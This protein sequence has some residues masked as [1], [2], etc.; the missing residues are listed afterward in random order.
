MGGVS[1]IARRISKNSVQY[2][3][4]GNGG[5]YCTTGAM[6]NKY[7]QSQER[8]EY[9]FCLGQLTSVGIPGSE[10]GAYSIL[11]AHGRT[12]VPHYMGTSERE[13]FSR[14]FIIDCT[15]SIDC[16]YFYDLDEKWYYVVP[17]PFYIKIPLEL[18]ANNLNSDDHYVKYYIQDVSKSIIWYILK[19]YAAHDEQFHAI[20]DQYDTYML[21]NRL[22][23][24]DFPIHMLQDEYYPIYNYFDN[25]VVIQADDEY[26]NITG[27]QMR[28]RSKEHIETI[29]WIKEDEKQTPDP[30]CET[31]INYSTSLKEGSWK[32]TLA[33]EDWL[34]QKID[35]DTWY[36]NEIKRLDK[37]IV[38]ND[39]KIAKADAKIVE[40]AT[41]LSTLHSEN[42][43]LRNILIANGIDPDQ[44]P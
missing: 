29:Y 14:N 11:K 26:K 32:Y 17:S 39:A 9:L 40:R 6:L 24:R 18:V 19:G 16:A 20:L 4:G 12:G 13:I 37:L 5:H 21:Q 3:L 30:E 25:W 7:Y 42:E 15:Y 38:E 1:I 10:K 28:P 34:R 35:H 33:H 8:V 31:P 44:Q 43:H 22:L 41:A 2:G 27:I 36:E 23:Y